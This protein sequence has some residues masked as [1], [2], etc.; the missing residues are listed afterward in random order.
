ML[1]SFSKRR[2]DICF[3]HTQEEIFHFQDMIN[4]NGLQREA[5][6][7]FIIRILLIS[8]PWALSGSRFLIIFKISSLVKRIV[9][10]DS[11][12]SFVKVVGSSLQV[13]TREHYCAKKVLNISAFLLKSVINL[14]SCSNG[15]IQE[16]FLLFKNIFNID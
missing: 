10:S 12:F 14:F 6:Q 7:S 1:I 13:F 15:G 8:W 4:S 2:N 5:S 3:F 16:I 11:W 9:D